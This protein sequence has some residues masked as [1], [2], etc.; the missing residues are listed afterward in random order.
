MISFSV[1]TPTYNRAAYLPNVY[2]SL[3]EQTFRNFEWIIVND[4]SQDS[5]DEIVKN[6][7]SENLIKIKYII[8]SN[9]GKHIAQ[10]RA[11]E[12]A[13]G[14]LFLPL[15]SDDT[16]IS[17]ALEILWNAWM[18]INVEKR[19]KYSGV[20]VHCMDVNG[21]IIGDL[22]PSD[23]FD[24]N[25][26]EIFFKYKIRGEKWGPIRTD[27]MRSYQNVEV[28][29]HFLSESTMWF[30]IAEKYQKKYIN[31]AIR[32][33]EIHDDSISR[34]IKDSKIDENAESKLHANLIYINEFWDWYWT[35]DRRGGILICLSALKAALNCN[36]P[37]II[38]KETLIHRIQ[39]RVARLI[40]GVFSPYKILFLCR[41][42]K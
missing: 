6:F 22:W 39:P 25:D 5:T 29:G 27:I 10:N 1:F 14:E 32:I 12:I 2:R 41:H 33:Y 20:G 18:S 30:R 26:L 17:T 31:K 21:R 42:R 24:S 3:R 16:I 38:G 15:D 19:E 9:R 11:T 36:I 34:R 7:M 35:Y 4:G 8:Q 23:F 40:I 28:K 37:L 13:E